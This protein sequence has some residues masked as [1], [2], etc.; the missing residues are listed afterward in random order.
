MLINGNPWRPSETPRNRERRGERA[1]IEKRRQI[2]RR[3][4]RN[5]KTP[6]ALAYEVLR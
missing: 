6:P 1:K 4:P 5:A 3:V 2:K